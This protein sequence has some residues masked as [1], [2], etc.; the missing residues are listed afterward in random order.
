MTCG[1]NTSNGLMAVWYKLAMPQENE[2]QAPKKE[3]V[4][5][6]GRWGLAAVAANS[7]IGSGIFGLPAPLAGHLGKLGPLAVVLTGLG[8]GLIVV[9]LAETAS[10][11]SASGGPYLYA[12][13]AFGRYVGIQTGWLFW[14]MRITAPAANGNL[15]VIYL[16][17][18]WPRAKDPMPRFM[19]LTL[20]IWGLAWINI[21][22]VRQGA[23]ISSLFIV[24][25]LATLL[26][27]VLAGTAYLLMHPAGT[28][29]ASNV[30][31]S[32]ALSAWLKSALLLAF[33]YGGFESSLALAGEATDPRRDP[34]FAICVAVGGCIVL[35]ALL[36]WVA[37]GTVTNLA[38]SQRPL[39][40]AA[41]ISLG[42]IGAVAVTIG[43]LVATF[44]N[45]TANML[46][47]PRITFALAE[48]GDFPAFLGAIHPRFRTPY[49]SILAFAFLNWMFTL[50]GSFTWNVLLSAIARL[51]VYAVCCAAL[52]V[53]RRKMPPN[54]G[55]R[56]PGGTVF[57]GAAILF[58]LLLFTQVN[59]GGAI[60]LF[61]VLLI[62]TCNWLAVRRKPASAQ[63]D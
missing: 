47:V 25:K 44:G 60:V 62:G 48:Q 1:A 61:A 46:A 32:P 28:A 12:R 17:E 38:H 63:S 19:I 51:F 21:R 6:I 15:F 4:R 33:A 49:F 43:A 29:A 10:H 9:C 58:C 20:L 7:V 57:A 16:A 52:P 18:F 41:R 31:S 56:L 53:L 35:F 37:I 24:A 55:F 14:L 34:G 11:F 39:T 23:Q 22:G 2:I 3:L 36:Q 59:F 13:A 54:D 42:W 40:D 50:V 8:M 26:T 45:L 5:A 30:V 27:V